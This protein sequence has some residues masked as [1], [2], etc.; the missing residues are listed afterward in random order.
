MHVLDYVIKRFPFRMHTV[1]SDRGHEFQAQVHW[2]L[3]DHGIR[4]VYIKART[5]T[6]T[7]P[8]IPRYSLKPKPCRLAPTPSHEGNYG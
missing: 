3:A 1:R 8:V 2:H 4:H 6:P 7:T 5:P